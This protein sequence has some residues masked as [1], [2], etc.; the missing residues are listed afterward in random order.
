M[1]ANFRSVSGVRRLGLGKIGHYHFI[2]CQF[3]TPHLY[4][5]GA[6]DIKRKRFISELGEGLVENRQP[7][8][9]QLDLDAA[10]LA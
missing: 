4:S 3:P 2:D 10:R 6:Q 8:H 1:V 5:L 9:W 7:E